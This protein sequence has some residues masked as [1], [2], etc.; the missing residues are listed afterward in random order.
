MKIF[1][2][3]EATEE[4]NGPRDTSQYFQS[5]LIWI[6]NE[7]RLFFF[8]DGIVSTM[9]SKAGPSYK[10]LHTVADYEKFLDSAQ[11]S[12]IGKIFVLNIEQQRFL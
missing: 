6:S 12:I 8:S 7:N 9:K 5:I 3:G 2:N 10:I 11:H 4:Y 1:K